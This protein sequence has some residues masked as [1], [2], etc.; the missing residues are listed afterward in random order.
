M[1]K[2]FQV[3]EKCHKYLFKIKDHSKQNRYQVV[4]RCCLTVVEKHL[5]KVSGLGKLSHRANAMKKR[6]QAD[7][8]QQI[9]FLF[10]FIEKLYAAIF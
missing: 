6:C 3:R 7:R 2:N 5:D 4:S 9:F 10:I 1:F 8:A